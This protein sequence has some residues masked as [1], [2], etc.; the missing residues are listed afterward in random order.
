MSDGEANS[1]ESGDA[2]S[3][4]IEE[5]D[6][7]KVETLLAEG[8]DLDNNGVDDGLEI[9][10]L[11]PPAHKNKNT[12]SFL[13]ADRDSAKFMARYGKGGTPAENPGPMSYEPDMGRSPSMNAKS[14]SNVLAYRPRLFKYQGKK[15]LSKSA[16]YDA[17]GKA[18][19]QIKTRGEKDGKKVRNLGNVSSPGSLRLQDQEWF[20]AGAAPVLHPDV[21]AHR[22]MQSHHS[23]SGIVSPGMSRTIESLERLKI[24]TVKLGKSFFGGS[25]TGRKYL[26]TGSVHEEHAK[27]K[28]DFSGLASEGC[29]DTGKTLL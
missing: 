15:I 5:G 26:L 3:R 9:E 24:D 13:G 17:R 12:S 18:L 11:L 21:F 19:F 1:T 8:V 22:T 4:A 20:K 23:E 29:A 14:S 6:D 28:I 7:A 25:P 16:K 27:S 10:A 2:L